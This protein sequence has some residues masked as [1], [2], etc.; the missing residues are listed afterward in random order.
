MENL[1]SDGRCCGSKPQHYKRKGYLYC[2]RCHYTYDPVTGA[3][4]GV[5]GSGQTMEERRAEIR[6][7]SG[8]FLLPTIQA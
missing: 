5:W 1:P 6:K 3:N 8:E 2:H 4:L 7:H